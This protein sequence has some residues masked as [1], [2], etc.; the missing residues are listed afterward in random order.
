MGFYKRS[1]LVWHP[2]SVKTLSFDSSSHYH[3]V[4]WSDV[5]S[6]L[7]DSAPHN[8]LATLNM[9]LGRKKH[10]SDLSLKS[11]PC[12]LFSRGWCCTQHPGVGMLIST[13]PMFSAENKP[14][15]CQSSFES[16][17]MVFMDF[18]EKIAALICLT[19]PSYVT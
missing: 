7:T 15:V 10:G 3:I 16:K 9:A 18:G 14:P 1:L 17:R 8:S 13:D 4:L 5:N 12:D 11:I 6:M 2:K 19:I